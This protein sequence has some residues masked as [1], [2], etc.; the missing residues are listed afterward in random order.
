VNGLIVPG[1]P[2]LSRAQRADIWRE[3]EQAEAKRGET[4]KN[5][6]L[7]RADV[8]E[9]EH[10]KL[11]EAEA[12]LSAERESVDTRIREFETTGKGDIKEL[13]VELR[14]LAERVDTRTKARMAHARAA[15]EVLESEGVLED[16]ELR[17]KELKSRARSA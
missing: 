1:Q 17:L 5:V 8:L 2:E 10:I 9:N 11:P 4:E 16:V 7:A 6:L 12:R 13:V 14:K 15:R 3:I